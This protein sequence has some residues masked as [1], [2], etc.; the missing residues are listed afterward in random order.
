MIQLPFRIGA[1][2]CTPRPNIGP[3]S[4]ASPQK[5]NGAD[6]GCTATFWPFFTRRVVWVTM[7]WC[8]TTEQFSASEVIPLRKADWLQAFWFQFFL[9]AKGREEPNENT[10]R[11]RMAWWALRCLVNSLRVR[12]THTFSSA[13]LWCAIRHG[14]DVGA[15]F[16]GNPTFITRQRFQPCSQI[17]PFPQVGVKIE[18][19]W[20]HHLAKVLLHTFF[21][22]TTPLTKILRNLQN[23][24]HPK[25]IPLNPT[26]VSKT[27][28]GKSRLKNYWSCRPN[29][30]SKN[31]QLGGGCFNPFSKSTCLV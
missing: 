1:S 15:D 25:Q 12:L 27:T 8:S 11:C 18:N 31:P 21:S 5:N 13:Q 6:H 7:G 26:P 20:N 9:T 19:T 30:F 4:S 3:R 10:A 2:Y 28:E 22:R 24:L 14:E 16:G 23:T 29:Q 17:G